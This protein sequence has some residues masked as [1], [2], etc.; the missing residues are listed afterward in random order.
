V[1]LILIK[2]DHPVPEIKQSDLSCF[3]YEIPTLIRFVATLLDGS[4]VFNCIKKIKTLS[5]VT[6]HLFPHLGD[7]RPPVNWN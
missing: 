1:S 7:G 3:E 6:V 2:S 5:M 4:Y